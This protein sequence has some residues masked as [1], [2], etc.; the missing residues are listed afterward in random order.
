MKPKISVIVPVYNNIKYIKECIDSIL[1]QTFLELEIICVDANSSD[2]TLEFLRNISKK[3]N[4]IKLIISE[5]KSLGYQLNLGIKYAQ[6]DYFCIVESDDYIKNNMC[7]KLYTLITQYKV[8]IVKADIL[9]FRGSFFGRKYTYKYIS[10]DKNL[11]NKVLS[12]IYR[13]VIIKKTWN[14]NQSSIFDINFVKKNNIK[15]NETFGASYQD[16]GLWF[17]LCCS[18]KK[19]YFHNE[20]FYY[21]RE[22]NINSSSN[23]KEKVYYVCDECDFIEQNII[24]DNDELRNIFYYAKFKIYIWNLYRIN[25]NYR[26]DFLKKISNDFLKISKKNLSF[27]SQND[28]K[29]LEQIIHDPNL[30]CKK[31]NSIFD[32]F[33]KIFLRYKRKICKIKQSV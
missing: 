6:G 27:L 33:K 32:K 13:N 18:Y 19:I 5:K 14:M 8:D 17:W 2:G 7:E 15:A 25:K 1:N 24:N 11:Y 29:I 23:N 30:Y 12:A 3:Y 26:L 20:A 21:Y 10:N 9:S 22:D 28:L 4:H 31:I 16:F